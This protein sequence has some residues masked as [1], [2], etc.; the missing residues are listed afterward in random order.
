MRDLQTLIDSNAKHFSG[1]S[2]LPPSPQVQ[3]QQEQQ[4]Q[5]SMVPLQSP[6]SFQLPFSPVLFGCLNLQ[7]ASYPLLS[8]GLLFSPTS[9]QLGFPQLPLSLTVPVLS[10][11]FLGFLFF[12]LLLCY[13]QDL[14][15]S[16]RHV[17]MNSA[18]DHVLGFFLLFKGL[19]NELDDG[20]SPFCMNLGLCSTESVAWIFILQS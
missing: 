11:A 9:S 14:G 18:L 12:G 15:P 17:T 10:S 19:I 8:I 5:Q 4:Q 7:L 6:S 3:P 16:G 1:F 20:N 13:L 2:P